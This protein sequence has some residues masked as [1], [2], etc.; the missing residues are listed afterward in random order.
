M[1]I[2]GGVGGFVFD[3]KYFLILIAPTLLGLHR[4]G[5]LKGRSGRTVWGVYAGVLVLTAGMLWYLGVRMNRSREHIL[6]PEAIASAVVARLKTKPKPPPPDPIYPSSNGNGVRMEGIV[7]PPSNQ[8]CQGMSDEDQI[9][10]LCPS[11]LVYTL[12]PLTPPPDNNYATEIDIKQV[13]RPIYR[14]RV[15]ARTM[16]DARHEYVP[17]PPNDAHSASS[18]GIFDYDPF[19]FV[20]SATAPKKGF[21]VIVH[22]SEG[23]RLKCI[24]QDN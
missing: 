13:D 20:I 9:T 7:V 1:G 22:S 24:N 3:G 10:C 14:L 12:R 21:N 11:P 19:S 16:I 17:D 5:A 18:L 2:V 4:S 15:F 23:L 8:M 6:T